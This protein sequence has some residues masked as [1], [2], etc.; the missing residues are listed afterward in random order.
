MRLVL[1]A[2]Q[3]PAYYLLIS[4][5][6]RCFDRYKIVYI[7]KPLATRFDLPI[8]FKIEGEPKDSVVFSRVLKTGSRSTAGLLLH[9]L[10]ADRR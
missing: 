10:V 6:L 7:P 9:M 3:P 5:E 8:A 2:L 1:K 4:V